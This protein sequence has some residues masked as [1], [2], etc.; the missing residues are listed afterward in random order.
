M[1]HEY[2]SCAGEKMLSKVNYSGFVLNI[3]LFGD[4]IAQLE[5]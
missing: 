4:V 3:R 1:M 2:L 5:G